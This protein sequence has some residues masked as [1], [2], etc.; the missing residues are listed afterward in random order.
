MKLP[1]Q[2]R[3]DQTLSASAR[4]W[5][6][7][8]STPTCP[9]SLLSA[10]LLRL[11][12]LPPRF[13][14]I[15]HWQLRPEHGT[16]IDGAVSTGVELISNGLVKCEISYTGNYYV[17]GPSEPTIAKITC[18][19]GAHRLG[20]I[21]VLFATTEAWEQQQTDVT[22]PV[23]DSLLFSRSIGYWNLACNQLVWLDRGALLPRRIS[24]I[25]EGNG[26]GP[27]ELARTEFDSWEW[28]SGSDVSIFDPRPPKDFREDFQFRYSPLPGTPETQERD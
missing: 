19:S 5:I 3:E 13:L 27:R 11:F 14:R 6:A 8:R 21:D 23:A 2:M 28:L 1:V 24:V 4:A 20:F 9:G 18:A 26:S 12:A 16:S 15:H 17:A 7:D 22:D 10:G 25:Q